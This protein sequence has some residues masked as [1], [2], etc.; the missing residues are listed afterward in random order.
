MICAPLHLAGERLMLCPSGTLHWPAERTLVVSDLHLEKGSA[1]AARGFFVPPYDTRETL[2]K[3]AHAIR[4]HAPTRL[5]LLGD[6]LHDD[7]ALDRMATS[8]L[9]ALRRMLSALEVIWISGNHDP[10]PK[11][12][13]G[14]VVDEWRR[15]RLVFRH[16][17]GGPTART[18]AEISGHYHPKATLPTRIG[19]VTRPCFLACA[20][21]LVLPAFGAFTGG[22]DVKDPALGAITRAA[23]R[24]FLIGDARLH[25]APFDALARRSA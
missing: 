24:V 14:E 5:V 12:L 21:R 11:A 16:I 18:E 8:D 2:A 13:P 25:S 22:L 15:N 3:L 7:A 20:Q 23:H 1:Q 9:V 10:S 4:R 6:A 17:G 19:G